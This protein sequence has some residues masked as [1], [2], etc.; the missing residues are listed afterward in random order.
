MCGGR[1]IAAEK[2]HATLAFL[3]DVPQ[4]QFDALSR[5]PHDLQAKSFELVL[6]Q[7][8]YWKDNRIAFAGSSHAPP[9]LGKLADSLRE[10]LQCAGLPF[11]PKPFVPH[12]TLLREARRPAVMP[13]FEPIGWPVRE[14]SLVRSTGG[15]Y[16][17][18]SRWPLD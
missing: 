12:V 15:R 8:R 13:A 7:P 5:A 3:G 2:S 1:R 9:E 18:L 14:F 10:R 4:E 6:D 17:V 11:D 16:E